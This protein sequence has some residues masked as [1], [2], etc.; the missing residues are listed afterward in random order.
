MAVLRIT[1][2]PLAGGHAGIPFWLNRSF[3]CWPLRALLELSPWQATRCRAAALRVDQRPTDVAAKSP[4]TETYV[5]RLAR[6]NGIPEYLLRRYPEAPGEL[7]ARLGG[8]ACV[9][10]AA[11]RTVLGRHLCGR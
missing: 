4:I 11:I 6:E 9:L 8:D 10:A 2:P 3:D 5:R 7:D 1:P